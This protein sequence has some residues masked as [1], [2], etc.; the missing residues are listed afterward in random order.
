MW[1]GARYLPLW[2]WPGAL[3]EGNHDHVYGMHRMGLLYEE[4][5]IKGTVIPSSYVSGLYG[6]NHLILKA[7]KIAKRKLISA[8]PL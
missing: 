7:H 1:S 2:L 3:V 5:F 4:P 6:I 8:T